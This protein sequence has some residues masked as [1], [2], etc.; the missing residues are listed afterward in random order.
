MTN[1]NFDKLNGLIPAIVQD[2]FTNKVLML[3]F[4]NREAL[5][6]SLKTGFATFFSR[7]RRQIW[8]KGETSG[9]FLKVLEIIPDCDGDTLLVK[10]SP[11]G[12][13]CHTGNDTCFNEQNINTLGFIEYLESV[14]ENRKQSTAEES[15]TAK[16]LSSGAKRIAKKIGE[17]AVELSLEAKNGTD[18]RL[19]DEAADLLYHMLVLLSSRNLTFNNVIETLKSRHTESKVS[20]CDVENFKRGEKQWGK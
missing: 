18:Q 19:L 20:A 2:A 13:V 16:L 17:E 9:N 3:G 8:T 10:V 6:V 4:M 1:L 5:E 11:Q 14:I 7:T 15:Y 12:P